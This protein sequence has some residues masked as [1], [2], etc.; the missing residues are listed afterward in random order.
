MNF[1]KRL[2]SSTPVV[3]RYEV[4]I[5][6]IIKDENAYLEEWINYHL[7]VGV[8]HFYIY[9]NGSRVPI[10]HTLKEIG[11]SQYTTVNTITGKAKQV[12]AYGD[13][14]KRYGGTS[15]WIAFIDTDEF[16][17]PKNVSHQLPEFLKE[18]EPYGGLGVNWLIFGSG[19]HIKRTHRPQL[20]SFTMRANESFH[21]NDHIKSI[22]QPRHVK[23][24][25]NA[26]SFNYI[27]GKFCVNENFEPIEGANS[28]TSVSKI[29]LNHYYCR[30]VE[31]FEE[32]M[33]R[34]IADTRNKRSMAQFEYHDVASNEVEDKTILEVK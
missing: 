15:Q 1:F 13:C 34:G 19:G 3:Q 16:I 12:K 14:I 22:V 8:E 25:R 9:D 24:A 30:S 6:C 27:E 21:V 28:P 17:L 26:H 29:Q 31:E 5:C 4:C 33:N 10:A 11:L 7:K 32:K 23:S 20:E 2:F 18:Y